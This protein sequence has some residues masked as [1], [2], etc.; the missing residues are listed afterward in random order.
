M[1]AD[2]IPIDN[3]SL[4]K[5]KEQVVRAFGFQDVVIVPS[6][7][8]KYFPFL[9]AYPFHIFIFLISLLRLLI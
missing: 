3:F 7:F 5:L 8:R 1:A 6:H 4:L 9:R 2:G